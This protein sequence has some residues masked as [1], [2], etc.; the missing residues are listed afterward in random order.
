M[1]IE[2]KLK[3]SKQVGEQREYNFFKVDFVR[4]ADEVGDNLDKATN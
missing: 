1:T 4:Q 3:N 2:S